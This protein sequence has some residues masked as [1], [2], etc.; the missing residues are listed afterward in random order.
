MLMFND[1]TNSRELLEDLYLNK[2]KGMEEI[3][4][5]LGVDKVVVRKELVRLN[6]PIRRKGRPSINRDQIKLAVAVCSCTTFATMTIT[7]RAIRI[8]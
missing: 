2:K 1:Y 5:L 7:R 3:G 6:F 4:E 8:S